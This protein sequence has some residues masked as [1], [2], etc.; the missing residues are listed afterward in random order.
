MEARQFEIDGSVITDIPAF[1]AE[2]NRVFMA[3]ESWQLADSLDAL[4]DLLYGG[5]GTMQG[6]EKVTLRWKDM[7]ATRA[8]LGPEC[9]HAFL[10]GRLGQRT[11]FNGSTIAGQLTALEQGRGTTYFDIVME[12]F[13]DHPNIEIVPA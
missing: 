5:Y 1:Y 11:M 9:T 8:A 4:N 13:A 3:G 2:I 12:V 7:A 10:S 6:A